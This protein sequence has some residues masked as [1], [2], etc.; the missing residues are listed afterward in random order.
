MKIKRFFKKFKIFSC[1]LKKSD[2]NNY[3]NY[4]YNRPG[5]MPGTLRIAQ[6]AHPTQITLIKYNLEQAITYTNIAA[7]DCSLYLD[8]NA[9]AWFD[10]AGLGSEQTLQKLAEVFQFDNYLLEDVVNV[11]QRAKIE[12]FPSQLLVIT[13]MVI[14]KH[15]EPGFWLE[16]VSFVMGENFLISL[17]EESSKDC[18]HLVRER[19]LQSKGRIRSLGVDYL[20]YA[21]W[22]AIIDGYYPV[23]EGFREQIVELE[24]EVLFNASLTTLEKIY[25]AKKE[26]LILSRAIWPQRTALEALIQEKPEF[27]QKRAYSG[28]KDCYDHTL[29]IIESIDI[30]NQLLEGLLN[31]YLSSMS[32]QTNEVMKILTIVSTIFIPL[33][34]IAGIYGM[35]FN[36]DVSPFNMPELNWYW[37][38][39][40]VLG[41]MLGISLFSI[42][43][44]WR[45]GWF[46]GQVPRTLV[47]FQTKN[48]PKDQ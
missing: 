28:L 11:P 43:F 42:F 45:K 13:Q 37:G 26:L 7:Q 40:F 19:I 16:Q 20:T 22:D 23:I 41:L 32:N 17:Q 8:N 29:Q 33:T 46:K 2:N 47:E 24:E 44:F 36:P 48:S 27:I 15:D 31:L 18:F 12:Y 30:G 21:L 35:N 14:P 10:V 34:F 4:H 5:S 39:P 6:N 25:L 38:Y 1:K 3:L 9:I